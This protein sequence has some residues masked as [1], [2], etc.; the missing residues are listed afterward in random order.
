MKIDF[1]KDFF[2]V[3]KNAVFKKKLWRMW[4][5]IELSNLLQ[6]TQEE[7]I[8]C[9]PNH[10]AAKFLAENLLAKEIKKKKNVYE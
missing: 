2:K 6:P 1:E 7:I 5:N 9:Q 8:I 3:M 4:E 10:H